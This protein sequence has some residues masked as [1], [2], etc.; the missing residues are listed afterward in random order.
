MAGDGEGGEG[1]EGG[2]GRN[3]GASEVDQPDQRGASDQCLVRSGTLVVEAMRLT[4][5][6]SD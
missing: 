6:P 3:R 2:K 4:R 1:G 5:M